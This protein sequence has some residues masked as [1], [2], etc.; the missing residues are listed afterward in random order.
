MRLESIIEVIQSL[1]VTGRQNVD[2]NGITYDSRQVRPGNLFV[3]VQGQHADGR[4][5]IRDAIRRGAVAIVSDSP[6]W[7]RSD[8]S[9][10]HV[11]HPRRALAEIAC[12]FYGNPSSHLQLIGIT[13]TNGKTTTAFMAESILEKAGRRPGL[14]G[15]VQY[16]I[17]ERSI[18]AIRTTPEAPELHA[19]LDQMVEAG[20][21]SA[22]MEVSSHALDQKRVWG[23]DFDVAVFTN[24]TREHLDYHKTMERYFAAKLQLFRGLGQMEKPASAVINIDDSWGLE[25]ANTQGFRAQCKTYGEHPGANVRAENITAG[26]EGC[27][28]DLISPWGNAEVHLELIGRFNVSNALAAISACGCLGVDLDIMLSALRQLRSVPGRME[29]VPNTRGFN[30][31]VDYAHTDDALSNALSTL[32]AITEKRLIVVFGCG[33]DRDKGKRPRMGKVASKFA[34]YTILTADNPRNENPAHIV[35]DIREGLSSSDSFEIDLDRRTAIRKAIDLARPGDTVLIA[36]KGHESYQEFNRTIVPFD[37][38]EI[39][40]QHLV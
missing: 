7:E 15:T 20:C 35:E 39:A 11:E 30:L 38:V 26:A 2:V 5:F 21:R 32:R 37:D 24:L 22:V 29:P 16:D 4:D 8:V 31:F 13:G 6:K 12:A 14:I 40:R 9:H 27:D 23:V 10:I 18:P 1:T 3:A 19:M 28:F 33:G 25:L 17:G 36:G 34:D